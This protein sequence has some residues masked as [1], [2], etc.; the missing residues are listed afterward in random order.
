MKG[1]DTKQDALPQANPRDGTHS[2]LLLHLSR[3]E[4]HVDHLTSKPHFEIAAWLN[5]KNIQNL[6][7][8]LVIEYVS[9]DKKGWQ[10]LD[11]SRQHK[12]KGPVLLSG[13]VDLNVEQLEELDIYFCHPSPA[14]QCEIEELLLNNKE[15]RIS[16]Q[17][18][19][20]VA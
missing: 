16:D 9:D 12:S 15:M 19:Y 5:L 3:R 18:F 7:S 20:N 10:I 14:I 11:T 17:E 2:E 1:L 4:L 8:M 6:P 13:V